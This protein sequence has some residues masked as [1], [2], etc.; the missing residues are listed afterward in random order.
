MTNLQ[1]AQYAGSWRKGVHLPSYISGYFDGE[2]Y[3]S[4]ALSPRSQLLVGWEVRPSGSV[5]QNGDRAQVVEEILHH[6]RCGTIRPDPGDKTV[7]GESRSF[8]AL[9]ESVLPHF[10]M[11]PLQS[12][13]QRDFELLD[14][15]CERMER[16]DHLTIPGLAEI[17]ELARMMNPSGSRRYDP[18][19]TLRDLVKKKA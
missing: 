7:K 6:F 5:S 1:T 10:R 2:G 14:E 17:V 3:F 19:K 16:R 12:G 8:R 11:Y 4:V 18:S 9:R 13:K 15:I